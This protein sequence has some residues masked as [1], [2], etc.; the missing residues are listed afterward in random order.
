MILLRYISASDIIC[1]ENNKQVYAPE[2]TEREKGSM[3][4]GS[5]DR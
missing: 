2:M 3:D 1:E 5:Y 4:Y